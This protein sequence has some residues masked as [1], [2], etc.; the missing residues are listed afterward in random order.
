M[1]FVKFSPILVGTL[2]VRDPL[3]FVTGVVP[4]LQRLVHNELPADEDK[5]DMCLLCNKYNIFCSS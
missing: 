4:A 2:E 1:A 3:G 5:D